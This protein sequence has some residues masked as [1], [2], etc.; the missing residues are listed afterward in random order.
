MSAVV[1]DKLNPIFE[2]I[3][4]LNLGYEIDKLKDNTISQLNDLGGNGEQIYQ[5][6]MKD[7]EKYVSTFQ[8][9]RVLSGEESFYFKDTSFEFYI[10]F[11]T[12]FL[13]NKDFVYQV[14]QMNNEEILRLIYDHKDE[15]FDI[16]SQDFFIES[17]DDF[18]KLKNLVLFI[19]SIQLTEGDKWKMFLVL[20]NPK[21]YYVHFAEIIKNNLK[22]YEVAYQSI[23]AFINKSMEVLLKNYNEDLMKSQLC[24]GKNLNENINVVV[25]TMAFAFGAIVGL[26]ECYYGLSLEKIFNELGK[27]SNSREYLIG[28]LKALSDKS[29]LEIL[30]SLKVSPKYATELAEQL[31]LT[32]ATVSHHMNTLLTCQMVYLEKENGRIYYHTNEATLN[33]IVEQLKQLIL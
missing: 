18:K 10:S 15:I 6:L 21:E 13:I 17:F 16:N 25:P 30:V 28:C 11:I 9:N 20:Q 23:E 14:S 2:T 4:L 32:T 1:K 27:K 5:K 19:E 22:A 33:N 26:P 8:K 31:N 3:V 24:I 29:K 12:P 7:F